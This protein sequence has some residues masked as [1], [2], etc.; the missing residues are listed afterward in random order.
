VIAFGLLSFAA[1]GAWWAMAASLEPS[2]ATVIG[3]MT[4]IG[5]GTGLC[6]PTMMGTATG[7]LPASSFATG[8]GVINMIRQTGMAV[9]V[10]AFVAIIGTPGSP[11]DRLVAFRHAWW[12][13]AAVVALGLIPALL[14]RRAS[15]KTASAS[16]LAANPQPS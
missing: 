14:L 7:A 9:G 13:M 4:L 2:Y 16:T 11:L 1:G 3:G 8:S 15:A 6:L 10:A 12:A 5:A